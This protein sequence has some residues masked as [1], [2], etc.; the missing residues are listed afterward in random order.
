MKQPMKQKEEVV[1]LTYSYLAGHVNNKMTG[2]KEEKIISKPFSWWAAA[3]KV[4]VTWPCV[5][6]KRTGRE[7]KDKEGNNVRIQKDNDGTYLHI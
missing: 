5:D 1:S 6:R 3:T 4:M 7:K 2:V